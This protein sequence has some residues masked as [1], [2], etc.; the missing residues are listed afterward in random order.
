M[1]GLYLLE[2]LMGWAIP[3]KRVAFHELTVSKGTLAVA[4][5]SG[6]MG[7][8]GG[9]LTVEVSEGVAGKWKGAFFPRGKRKED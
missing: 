5:R 6:R 4:R 2:R 1:A 9:G 3:T 8:D 7:H